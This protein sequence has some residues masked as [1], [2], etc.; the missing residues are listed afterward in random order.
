[1]P[2]VMTESVTENGSLL[3]QV[4]VKMC[5]KSAQCCYVS[6]SS[7]KPRGLKCYVHHL[8]LAHTGPVCRQRVGGKQLEPIGDYRP[9]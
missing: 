9:R 8:A 4:I 2:G 6:S 1:M 3:R 5:G 7:D